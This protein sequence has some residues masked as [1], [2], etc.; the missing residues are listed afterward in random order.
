MTVKKVSLGIQ[1]D[2]TGAKMEYFKMG[3]KNRAGYARI[4]SSVPACEVDRVRRELEE[5]AAAATVP[6][7]PGMFS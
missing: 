2:I 7:S 6:P 3:A 4:Y 1:E 5:Y